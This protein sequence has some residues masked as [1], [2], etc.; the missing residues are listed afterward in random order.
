[1]SHPG[2]EMISAFLAD[3]GFSPGTITEQR[4]AMAATAEHAPAEP[5]VRVEPV[6]LGGRPAESPARAIRAGW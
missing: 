6:T 1:V 4:A 2:V 5:G 3:A